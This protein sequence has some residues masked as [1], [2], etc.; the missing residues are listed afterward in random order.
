[1]LGGEA[2]VFLEPG[3]GDIGQFVRKTVTQLPSKM[4][5]VAAQFNALLDDDLWL[6][7]AA[8]AN[9]MAAAPPRRTAAIAGVELGR[10][11]GVNSMFPSLP[12]GGDR[13]A[14]GV[15][16]LLGLGLSAPPGALDDRLG[17]HG[18]RRRDVRQRRGEDPCNVQLTA[19]PQL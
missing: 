6:E 17:H 7:L 13:A 12:A 11:A 15:E 14:A 18:R 8:H 3:T 19:H 2:V 1:M 9:A 5:F 4:R 10:A 16:L